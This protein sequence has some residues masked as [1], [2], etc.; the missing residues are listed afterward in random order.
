MIL[1]RLRDWRHERYIKRVSRKSA[2]ALQR[3]DRVKCSLY[4]ALMVAAI[5]RRSPGQVARM[6]KSRNIRHA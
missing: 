3:N 1:Q 4:W 5:N 6:E 2:A